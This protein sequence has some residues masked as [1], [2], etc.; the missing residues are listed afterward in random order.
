MYTNRQKYEQN[1]T[2][3]INS[4]ED[5]KQKLITITN[6]YHHNNPIKNVS[7]T[8]LYLVLPSPIK[9]TMRGTEKFTLGL[10]T[11]LNNYFDVTILEPKYNSAKYAKT[12]KNRVNEKYSTLKLRTIKLMKLKLPFGQFFY[13]FR[14]LPK[15]GIIYLPFDFYSEMLTLL[16]KPKG[17]I[18]ILGVAHGLHLQNGELAHHGNI[19][20]IILHVAKI[21]LAFKGKDFRETVYYHTNNDEQSKYLLKAGMLKDHIFQIP[22][23]TDIS[24]FYVSNNNS[25]KLKVLNIGGVSKNADFVVKIIDKLTK[26]HALNK[27][28]FHFIGSRVPKELERYKKYKNIIVHGF[29]DDNKKAEIMSKMDVLALTDIETFSITMLEG[30]A[31]GLAIISSDGNPAAFELKNL[32]ASIYIAKLSNINDYITTLKKVSKSKQEGI[33]NLQRSKNRDIIIHN[34][35]EEVVFK[36]IKKSLPIFDIISKRRFSLP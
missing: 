34:Y 22:N 28:E 1:Y 8:K 20:K 15:D 5:R 29:I 27:Y 12:D 14:G 36:K 6:N 3:L 10:A 30:L 21:L 32:G 7:L 35:S 11:Y 31:S 13:K 18:Y 9:T 16:S 4:S 2:G 23:F 25:E 26:Q 24:K 19:G 33:L 17:Q